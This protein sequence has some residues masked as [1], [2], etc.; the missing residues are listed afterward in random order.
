MNFN[1]HQK[2]FAGILSLALLVGFIDRIQAGV[3]ESAVITLIFPPG[4]RAT[5]LGEAF[6]GLCDDANATFYNPA[7][8]GQAP[9]ANSWKL[10]LNNSGNIF[11]SI[12]AKKRKDFGAKD[13]IWVGTNKGLLRYNG[14]SWE[15]YESYLVEQKDDIDGIISKFMKTDDPVLLKNAVWSIFT[16]NKISQKHYSA[17]EAQIL[18]ALQIKTIANAKQVADSL[19]KEIVMVPSTERSAAKIYALLSGTLDSLKADTLSDQLASVFLTKDIEFKDLDEVKIPFSIAV[20]D[21]ITCLTFDNSN[22][23]WAGTADGL[24][25][26]SNNEWNRYTIRDGLPSNTVTSIA[27]SSS[28]EL[29]VGTD[30]GLA[31]YVDGQW[32]K[33]DTSDGLPSSMINALVY[34]QHGILYVGTPTGLVKTTDSSITVYDTANGLLSNN[35]HSLYYDSKE[36][37]WIGGDNGVTI[38]TL[39]SWKRFKFPDS[40]VVCFT[41]N[42]DG[43]IWIGTNNGVIS[44]KAGKIAVDKAG[45]TREAP[46]EWKS[47]HSKNALSDN[48]VRSIIDHDN[49]VW[50]ATGKAINEY[51]NAQRQVF[52]FYETLLPSFHIENL[53]HAY[54]STIYPTQDWGTIG[55]FVNYINMG[56]NTTT[57]AFGREDTKT[58]KS[59]EGVFGLSYGFSLKEDLSL[60]LNLKYVY[61]ALAPGM[62]DGEGVGQT[63]A[64]DLAVLKRNFLIKK[65]DMGFMF[66]NMGPNIF[67]ID[68][69]DPDPLPFTLRLGFVYRPILTP[70]SDLKFLLDLNREFVNIGSDGKPDP[71]YKALFTDLKSG[72]GETLEDK[73]QEINVNLG[74]EYWYANF[75]AL[76]T[77]FL[78][79]YV[80]VRYEWTLGLGLKYGTLNADWSYIYSP[81]GFMKHALKHTSAGKEG[82]SGVRDGQMRFSFLFMF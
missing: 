29:S 68:R 20:K 25:R 51:D 48:D 40:K 33:M 22:R 47:F 67:Y 44:Y 43:N 6:T 61:S 36:R 37:L 45:V 23:L 50:I 41:E 73:M 52:L 21:S 70:T 16:F 3:G 1:Y 19:S 30:N 27:A 77:G 56:D 39:S 8:L 11:T 63:F 58:R 69:S 66:Q 17:V 64:G 75:V 79:D 42:G 24:W 62:D 46:P 14:K 80:G 74:L 26:Y 35:V 54:A 78:A 4:A 15:N 60:G 65:F 28:G 38:S 32:K 7:G 31:S 2:L 72:D 82:S 18:N 12:A 5:A 53:W 55:G 49:D 57:D 10:H 34:S 9:L 81:E 76:R 13:L 59:W 71:F